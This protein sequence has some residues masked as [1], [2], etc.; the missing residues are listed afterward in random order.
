MVSFGSF[1]AYL[2][3]LFGHTLVPPKVPP[4]LMGTAL[5]L[6]ATGTEKSVDEVQAAAA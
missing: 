3:F 5:V 1:F 4:M 6:V 2:P